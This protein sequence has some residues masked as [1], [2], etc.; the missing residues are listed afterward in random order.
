MQDLGANFFTGLECKIN[1]VFIKQRHWLPFDAPAWT[2][3]PASIEIEPIQF[4]VFFLSTFASLIAPFGGFFAS[5]IK[6]TFHI[7]DFGDSIPGHGGITDRFDCQFIMGTLTYM[8]Y[9]GFIATHMAS[10]GG[11]IEMAIIGL[12]LEE[13]M[14]VIKGLS[15]HLVN[16]GVLTDSVSLYICEHWKL[17]TDKYQV[18]EYL[19]VQPLTLKRR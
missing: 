4:H 2:H 6:R 11:V 1:P 15:K 7:K 10:V 5:G 9:Q 18:M 13:Q 3:I 16:Q 8:Y 19:A 17:K 14:E 12:T